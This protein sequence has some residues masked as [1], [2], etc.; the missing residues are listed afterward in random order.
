M[1]FTNL[2]TLL[3]PCTETEMR[4]KYPHLMYIRAILYYTCL[5]GFLYM[6][7]VFDM[8]TA[9][10]NFIDEFNSVWI[11][12]AV[13]TIF[14]IIS[15]FQNIFVCY[16]KSTSFGIK[17]SGNDASIVII[18]THN[19]EN[20]ISKTLESVCKVFQKNTIYIADNNST[21]TPPDNI[22]DIIIQYGI[23]EE[24]YYYL[25][26]AS[27]TEAMYT[28]A[29][30]V[31]QTKCAQYV[32]LLDDDTVIP[33]NFTI[34]EELFMDEKVSAIAYS[35]QTGK[36]NLVESLVDWEY[37][38][39]GWRNY[40][41]SQYSTVKFALG[42]ISVWRFDRFLNVYKHNPCRYP[43]L[44]FG[45]DGWAGYINRTY[46]YRIVQD[47]RFTV[48]T[49]APSKLFPNI[50][51]TQTRQGYDS[52]NLWK[53]R[54]HR[55]Y[56]NYIRRLPFELC[57]LFR[58]DTGVPLRNVIYRFETLYGLYIY[59]GSVTIPILVAKL[60]VGQHGLLLWYI[61]HAGLYGSGLIS[62][63]FINYFTMRFRPDLRV[64]LKILLLYPLFTLYIS[65]ARLFGT[66]SAILYYIAWNA[67]YKSI[68]HKTFQN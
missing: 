31:L 2:I 27:K 18:P 61:L 14:P 40:F 11:I 67:P 43:G 1:R 49:F 41:K 15:M 6:C 68:W 55:W 37:K 10:W 57:L 66:I 56:R 24:N 47:L 23:P 22:K 54:A 20:G 4:K 46:N 62:N 13:C 25:P 21:E 63:I 8:Y 28:T 38:L 7:Y 58:Y 44:P 19:S 35:I 48:T 29:R 42:I 5:F 65:Y 64:S 30:S 60:I 36:S 16:P 45:E 26:V 50:F 33:Y 59:M 51:S 52:T 3:C 32:V 34:D 17:Y 9:Y 53:Q 12:V 39:Y